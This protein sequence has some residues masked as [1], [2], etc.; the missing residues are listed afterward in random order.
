MIAVI[1]II[2]GIQLNS[3]ISTMTMSYIMRF[4]SVAILPVLGRIIAMKKISHPNPQSKTVN[5][6]RYHTHEYV[7]VNMFKGLINF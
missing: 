7:T 3:K 6:M 4:F 1:T 2:I 5:L